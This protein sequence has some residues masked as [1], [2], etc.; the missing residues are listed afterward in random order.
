M[1]IISTSAFAAK[2][3]SIF[4][5]FTLS[6][7]SL[8]IGHRQIVKED[9]F[10][11]SIK[12]PNKN[13]KNQIRFSNDET[14]LAVLP[15]EVEIEVSQ[16]VQGTKRH[17]H[18]LNRDGQLAY[19]Y[20][21]GGKKTSFDASAEQW[22]ANQI[23][24]ILRETGAD[25]KQRVQRIYKNDDFEGIRQ[26]IALIDNDTVKRDYLAFSMSSLVLSE[27]QSLQ[28]IALANTIES[29]HELLQLLL[30]FLDSSL[31][32]AAVLQLFE[33]SK[34]IQSDYEL[35]TLLETISFD[36]LHTAELQKA[37]FDIGQFIQSDYELSQ[38]FIKQAKNMNLFDAGFAASL[39]ALSTIQS[40]FE[41][42]KALSEMV[43]LTQSNQ[44]TVELIRLA[45]QN[46]QLDYELSAFLIDT[47]DTKDITDSLQLSIREAIIQ[48]DSE[49]EKGK[50]LIRL[51]QKL[52]T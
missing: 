37:F 5:I 14:A 48:I 47:I 2:L 17:L 50:V 7:C 18:V 38:V 40:D 35:G 15:E 28:S 4:I 24:R 46:I 23:P 27:D 30:E 19:I 51:N 52:M 1:S 39:S 22:F 10:Y 21:V 12:A 3:T 6:A 42:R 26:E 8:H 45:S 11:L 49:Y 34:S 13:T 9:G 16:T 41:M 31:S 44:Y 43:M 29:D 25:Y 32:D 20:R 36:R 33:V